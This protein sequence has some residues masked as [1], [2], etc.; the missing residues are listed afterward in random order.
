MT[1]IN[2]IT[3]TPWLASACPAA[4]SLAHAQ[5]KHAQKLRSEQAAALRTAV[6]GPFTTVQTMTVE[7]QTIDDPNGV[8]RGPQPWRQ[9]VIT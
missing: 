1:N 3:A 8:V 2:T 5:A 6:Y 4:V 9:L 7:L